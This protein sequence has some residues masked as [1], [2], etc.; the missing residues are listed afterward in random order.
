MRA[1]SSCSV[2]WT[3]DSPRS[4]KAREAIMIRHIA[5][6]EMSR[7][8]PN[9]HDQ[10]HESTIMTTVVAAPRTSGAVKCANPSPRCMSP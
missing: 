10:N 9:C 6:I 8:N 4:H 7:D 3:T 5:G 2:G 1:A